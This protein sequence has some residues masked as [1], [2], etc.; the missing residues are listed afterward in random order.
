MLSRELTLCVKEHNH[1]FAVFNNYNT[2][3]FMAWTYEIFHELSQIRNQ[4]TYV[5]DLSNS[6][7]DYQVSFLS[8]FFREMQRML[9]F[10]R[11]RHSRVTAPP[12]ISKWV[13]TVLVFPKFLHILLEII[14]CRNMT[15]FLIT[16]HFDEYLRKS[17]HSTVAGYIGSVEYSI[18]PNL[19]NIART[20]LSYLVV[21]KTTDD[22][23]K[24]TFF[25]EVFIANGRIVNSAATA[26]AVRNLGIRT[27]II[28]RGARPGKFE[29]FNYSPHSADER[30][31]QLQH[32]WV[33]T[34][35]LERERIAQEYIDLR[36]NVDPI[37]GVT[38]T[39]NMSLGALPK[40]DSRK[41]CVIYTSTELE[42][43]V[44]GDS[45][46][47][48][49]FPTQR[50]AVKALIDALSPDDWQVFVR[51]HPYKTKVR[52]DPEKRNWEFL[53]LYP[54]VVEIPPDSP[55][56][57]Y[58]LGQVA[59]LVAHYDSSI[60]PELIA[61]QKT[62][63]ISIGNVFWENPDSR[64]LINSH[65]RMESADFTK[66]SVRNIQDIYPWAL[67]MSTFGKDFSKSR[68]INSQSFIA[69]KRIVEKPISHWLGK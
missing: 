56:D 26:A 13:N 40:F 8:R 15:N 42:F 58:A 61:T 29:L 43:A 35:L 32:T 20:L 57:S 65:Q 18:Y 54:N 66:L 34:D 14:K 3:L 45:I 53:S 63:V 69:G 12:R 31:S 22:Q 67:Y 1:S 7:Y 46:P 41:L 68:W 60:G 37:S 62:H 17:V 9:C 11:S 27:T 33:K 4:S 51:R 24:D 64:Y 52:K 36:R 25:C 21:F 47:H 50:E 28:E 44:F 23:L 49:S 48:G 10:G 39:R 5:F 55:V 19:L 2:D 59:N 30:R 6:G 38:W 16:T